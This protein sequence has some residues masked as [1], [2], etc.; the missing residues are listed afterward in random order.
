MFLALH[1]FQ[2]I[3][4]HVARVIGPEIDTQRDFIMW[5]LLTRRSKLPQNPERLDERALLDLALERTRTWHPNLRR[6][7]A[8]TDATTVLLTPIRS[9][10]PVDPW[11]PT[12]VTLLGD[13]IHSMP[14]T[15]GIG[16]NTALRDAELLTRQ[17]TDVA[18]CKV[19]VLQAIAEYETE[20]RR[21]AFEAVRQSMR[22]LRRQQLTENP[23]A[24][25]LMKTALRTL[26]GVRA[27]GDM[28][29]LRRLALGS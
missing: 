27:L 9:S 11:Q 29:P 21:Y 26:G 23:L 8:A 24:L 6:L 7:L 20:M 10:V 1:E 25:A 5:G 15:G 17:L 28:V 14:P 4:S 2:P 13:A 22:N 18:R 3:P 12:T 16:A 19:S